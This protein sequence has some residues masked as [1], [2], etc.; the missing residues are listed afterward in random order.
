MFFRKKIQV[1]GVIRLFLILTVTFCIFTNNLIGAEEEVLYPLLSPDSQVENI[2][3]LIGDGMGLSQITSARI[4]NYGADKRLNIEKMPVTGLINTH[5][6]ND[7][8]TDSGAAGTALATGYKTN[9]G[10]ISVSPDGK[11]LRTILEACRDIGMSSGL[12]VTCTITHATPAVFAS[13]VM[14]RNDEATIASQLLENKVNVMLGGGRMFFLP[15]SEPGS[16]RHDERNLLV[17]AQKKGYLY[18]QTKE[19]LGESRGNYILG[20]FQLGHLTTIPPE[21]SLGEM[22]D[23]AIELLRKNRKGFFLMVEGSQIDWACHD[24]DTDNTIRQTLLFDE[25]VKVALDF[26]LEN[27]HTLV[28]VTADHECGGMGINSGSLDGKEL[29]IGWTT[30]GHSGVPV[31][32]YAFGPQAERF[33]GLKD[34]TEIPRIFAELL[35]IESFHIMSE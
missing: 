4:A 12:V 17:E 30:K 34:N 24:N 15:E 11:R 33:M 28:L 2:I 8:I 3:F 35:G 14:S 7:L 32:V 19:E 9:N 27:K 26:A 1:F 23:K 25:A 13:H 5:S 22:T 31:P 29:S 10:M 18:I 21:P 20:L 6:S 16:K